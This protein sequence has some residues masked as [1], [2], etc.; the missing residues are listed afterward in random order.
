MKVEQTDIPDVKILIPRIF[1]DHRGTFTKLFG[2]PALHEIMGN[3][4]IRQVNRSITCKT[5]M[6]RGLHYQNPPFAEMKIITCLRGKVWDVAVDLRKG[7]TTFLKWRSEE[8][9]VGKECRSRGS[10]DH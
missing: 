5:G 1:E 2:A 9:R 3:R 6:I 10:P 7:S 8:R 4:T